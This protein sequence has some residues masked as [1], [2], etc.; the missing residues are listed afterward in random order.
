LVAT[1]CHA[2]SAGVMDAR[3]RVLLGTPLHGTS[4]VWGV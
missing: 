1:E 2:R 4:K 3:N